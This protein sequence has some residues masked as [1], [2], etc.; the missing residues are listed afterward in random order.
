MLTIMFIGAVVEVI[1]VG[2]RA[3]FLIYAALQICASIV[4]SIALIVRF[5]VILVFIH[6]Q[7]PSKR[8]D[9]CEGEDAIK[10]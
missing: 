3:T 8:K 7:M 10:L 9:S 2:T 1:T 5:V 6:V 4:H